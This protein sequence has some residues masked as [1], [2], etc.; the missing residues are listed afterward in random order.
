M[1]YAA[2]HLGGIDRNLHH[3]RRAL[4]HD[5][6]CEQQSTEQNQP[7]GTMHERGILD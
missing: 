7:R 1:N 4:R 2:W 5:G 6:A 3:R